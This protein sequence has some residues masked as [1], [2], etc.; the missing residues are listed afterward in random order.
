MAIQLGFSVPMQTLALLVLNL[1]RDWQTEEMIDP[2]LCL[3]L[4]ELVNVIRVVLLLPANF[5]EPVV[6]FLFEFLTAFHADY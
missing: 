6:Y 2:S 4:P 3:R 1:N 5:Q